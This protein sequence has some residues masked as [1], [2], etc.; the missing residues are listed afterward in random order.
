MPTDRQ[1]VAAAFRGRVDKPV[2]TMTDA[3]VHRL[4][5]EVRRARAE[6]R[7]PERQAARGHRP[8]MVG[9]EPVTTEHPKAYVRRHGKRLYGAEAAGAKP[10]PIRRG[11]EDRT[12][13]GHATL[14]NRD[15]AT[16]YPA[17]RWATRRDPATGVQAIGY[18]ELQPDWIERT[19]SGTPVEPDPEDEDEE[20]D[21]PALAWRPFYTGNAAGD[22]DENGARFATYAD[23]K[24]ARDFVF[25]PGSVE[26]I[27]IR[28][29]G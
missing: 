10:A 21:E 14:V 15:F 9:G 17:W 5:R 25:V 6:G 20:P 3:Y 8:R 19:K 12:V 11:R 24:A 16:L 26:V 18:G 1:I 2:R 13:A 23:A 28:V 22:E 4:A 29:Q 7:R 27:V